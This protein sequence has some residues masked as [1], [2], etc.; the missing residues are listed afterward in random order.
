MADLRQQLAEDRLMRDLAKEFVKADIDHV[1][2]DV[3]ERG[4]AQRLLGRAQDGALDIA[5]N[6]AE[7]AEDHKAKVGTG[8]LFGIGA[9]A[10][11]LF[12]DRILDAVDHLLAKAGVDT[13]GEHDDEK[14]EANDDSVPEQELK[15]EERRSLRERLPF[16]D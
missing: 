12:R 7:Y 5:D 14:H 16:G 3:G 4:F 11:W 6:A 8:L 1:R 15:A 13:A 2:G 10:A 9:F